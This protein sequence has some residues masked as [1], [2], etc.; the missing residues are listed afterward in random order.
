MNIQASPFIPVQSQPHHTP[1]PLRSSAELS[2]SLRSQVPSPNKKT[3][4]ETRRPSCCQHPLPFPSSP[5]PAAPPFTAR[6][7]L[8]PLSW[9]ELI[10]RGHKDGQDTQP[11]GW[12]P[13][14][15]TFVTHPNWP[16]GLNSR[17][18]LSALTRFN[19]LIEISWRSCTFL[20][21]R[22]SMNSLITQ[23][24]ALRTNLSRSC[25]NKVMLIKISIC[26]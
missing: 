14:G 10:L 5:A 18:W 1:L 24:S 9:M 15:R 7:P 4:Q 3:S 25:I 23:T 8:T 19:F 16:R 26:A 17:P 21:S 22:P 11:K 6:S 12:V 20:I 13:G 2:S